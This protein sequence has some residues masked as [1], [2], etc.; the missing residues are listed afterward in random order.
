MAEEETRED[1]ERGDVDAMGND[2]RRTVVGKQYGA[3]LR[4]RLIVYGAVVG[5]MILVVIAFLTVVKNIDEREVALK[6]T[7]PW[8]RAGDDA[9]T[10]RDVDFKANGPRDNTDS[11]GVSSGDATIPAEQVFSR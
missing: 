11:K 4:K 6:D 5:V 8:S 2:K 7:A 3:T 1:E 10:P 9:P